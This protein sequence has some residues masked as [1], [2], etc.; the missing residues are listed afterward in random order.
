MKIRKWIL[1][2]VLLHCLASQDAATSYVK[3]TV[4]PTGHYLERLQAA[5]IPYKVRQHTLYVQEK[6][7]R[8]VT[9]CC[10]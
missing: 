1:P 4:A 9:S 10:T 6:D 5:D 8:R 2:L 3:W 7:L